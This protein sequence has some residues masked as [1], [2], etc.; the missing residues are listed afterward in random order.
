MHT[1]I[2]MIESENVTFS[3]DNARTSRQNK[4]FRHFATVNI[5]QSSFL[6]YE[7]YNSVAVLEHAVF[8]EYMRSAQLNVLRYVCLRATNPRETVLDVID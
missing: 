8:A 4:R 1:L 3:Q 6:R 5:N 2:R 7:S